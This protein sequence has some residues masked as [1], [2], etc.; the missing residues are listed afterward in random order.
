MASI[1]IIVFFLGFLFL[2]I[3][4][5][6][7]MG[8]GAILYIVSFMNIPM[9]IVANQML[10]GVGSYTLM[11]IPFFIISGALME[12]GGIS[13]RLISFSTALVGSLPGG[14]ALVVIVA[15]A[16]FAAMTGSG[17]ACVAAIGGMM[18]PALEKNGYDIDFSCAL[19]AAGGT[20]GPM[21][22]P[23]ILMVLYSV[24]TGNSVGDMLL[25][26]LFPGLL[27][28]CCIM[29]ITVLISI[30]KGYRGGAPFSL[31]RVI[32]SFKDSIWALLTPVT[33]LGGI[34]SG[35]FTPTEAAAFSCFYAII[36][37]FFVYKELTFKSLLECLFKS[38]KTTGVILSIVAVTQLFSW[39]MTREGLPQ[40]IALMSTNI[41][42]NPII[43]MFIISLIL[44]V[45][46]MF[47]DPVPAV[48]IFAPILTPS[49][50]AM[51]LSPIHFGVVM[52]STFCIGLVTPPVGMT[53]Y[54]AA[55]IGHR[56]VLNVGK[57]V[58]PFLIAMLI[59]V[60]I[61]I[62]FPQ[63]SLFLPSLGK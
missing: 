52:V 57:K 21:I 49:A 12:T 54:V 17:A 1:M 47:L 36:I 11:A 43:F 53:L 55:N 13:K 25:A 45:V 10:G 37:G 19:Q 28:A 38:V 15:S 58:M 4:V 41:S 31:K 42:N 35:I 5:V 3:P 50:I 60:V 20:L 14:L 44:L 9:N 6:G 27:I 24:S 22:P 62:L 26:G 32:V 16:F 40:K 51:G 61:I 48:L 34:Y 59:A 30:K 46:G 2:G 33:I 63:I 39:I 7:A 29:V 8:L 23:S 18:I 56:P